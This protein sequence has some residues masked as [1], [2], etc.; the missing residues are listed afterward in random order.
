MVEEIEYANDAHE[1]RPGKAGGKVGLLFF[2]AWVAPAF[3]GALCAALDG[4]I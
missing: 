2:Q 4:N 1:R 3:L